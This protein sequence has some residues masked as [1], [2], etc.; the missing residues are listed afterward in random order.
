MIVAG[1]VMSESAQ[2]GDKGGGGLDDI[3]KK[4]G[5]RYGVDW[6]LLKAHAVVESSLNPAAINPAD[7]SYG[8]MQVLCKP[9]Q[10]GVCA[11]RFD[12]QGWAG[13]TRDRL[14]DPDVNVMIGAQ[15]VAWN[16]RNF[17]MPKAV[18]VFNR[19]DQ[20]IAHPFGPFANQRY[21]DRVLTEYRR[22]G[23]VA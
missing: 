1:V 20:R 5:A 4:Y 9:G 19:W 2:A 7:P 11:N 14:L 15:I 16:V 22:L 21:V 23:G 6:R 3:F 13:M 17:G 10:N 18:A 8:V 12:V